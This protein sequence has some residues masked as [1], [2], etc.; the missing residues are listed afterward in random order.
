M[1]TDELKPPY[2]IIWDQIKDGEVVPFLGAG[3]SL[4]DRPNDD[5]GQPLSWTGSDAPFL[6]K[7]DE[8]GRW[9]A[10]KCEF[11]DPHE[12]SD[13][14]K[15]ASYYEIRARRRNLVRRLRE[16]FSKEYPHGD[17]H[18]LLAEWPRPLLI[19]TTNYDDLIEKAFA[20]RG[21]PYH[22]V[23]HPER[24][25]LAGSVLWWKPGA[26]EP[27]VYTPSLLPL[28]PTDTSIIYKMHGTVGRRSSWNSFVITEEDYVGFLA[29]MTEK[30]AIP[31]RFMLHFQ[32]ASF[33]FLG[34]SLRDWNLRVMLENLHA[35]V[36]YERKEQ[37]LATDERDREDDDTVGQLLSRFSRDE[38]ELPS[39]AIQDSPSDL[40]RTLWN[41]RKVQIFDVTLDD[42][43]AG[44]RATQESS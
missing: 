4:C 7:G 34:Y 26:D 23:T 42:F 38:T 32:K 13:L 22:L 28:S 19:V 6:P 33:L 36:R 3:A 27:E 11:P 35:T 1:A 5:S 25:E 21:R 37:E 29:R 10:A 39:W 20:A 9:L 24:E 12:S 43:V 44:M 8:L 16:V 14:A 40:E 31:A 2:G 18:E 17:I 30:L 41:H 15:I